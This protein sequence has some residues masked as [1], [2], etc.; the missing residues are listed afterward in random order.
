MRR[1]FAHEAV[2]A[3]AP[4]GDS[5]APGG[6]VTV[7]LCGHWEH[8]PPCPFAPHHT[9]ASWVGSDLHVRILFAVEPEREDEARSRIDD[10]LRCERLEGPDGQETRWH[11][12]ST[13]RSELVEHEIDHAQ[14]L[15]ASS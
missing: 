13:G 15:A 3:M 12:L 4:Q 11:V 10:A 5:R 9:N 1:V 8:E 14:R 2:L 6:A 7:G